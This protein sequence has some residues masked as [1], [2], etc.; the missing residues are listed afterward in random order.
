MNALIYQN[1]CRKF[2]PNIEYKM[3]T[4]TVAFR[5]KNPDTLTQFL[6][7]AAHLAQ[8]PGV[9]EF[10]ILKQI[11]KKNAFTHALSMVFAD[12]SVYDAYNNHADHQDFVNSVWIPEVAE[13]IELDY[14]SA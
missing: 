4:H 11:G 13:F 5:L 7:T 3:I 6:D 14:V 9:Q 12:Q 1:L 2:R 10:K 8:V